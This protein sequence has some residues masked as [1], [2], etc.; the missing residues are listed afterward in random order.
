[1]L[2]NFLKVLLNSIIINWRILQSWTQ[3]A[4]ILQL[5]WARLRLR[6][7]VCSWNLG[8]AFIFSKLHISYLHLLFSLESSIIV[9]TNFVEVGC[10]IFWKLLSTL[11]IFLTLT[12]RWLIFFVNLAHD[13]R[14]VH[15]S[16]IIC[17]WSIGLTQCL[18][19]Q[20]SWL[21]LFH[22]IA[23]VFSPLF[24]NVVHIFLV[25]KFMHFYSTRSLI[26][27]AISRRCLGSAQLTSVIHANVVAL[28]TW[29]FTQFLGLLI[30]LS[31][32][33]SLLVLHL[34]LLVVLLMFPTTSNPIILLSIL[35]IH[36]LFFLMTLLLLLI[37]LLLVLLLFESR[38]SLESKIIVIHRD[39]AKLCS[40]VLLLM[41]VELFWCWEWLLILLLVLL[42]WMTT[43]RH[44]L[45]LHLLLLLLPVLTLISHILWTRLLVS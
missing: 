20:S 39:A 15:S 31:H 17:R 28:V 7:C 10:A 30:F 24:C 22:E 1:M 33:L 45:L 25:I 41:M 4:R 6:N 36:L 40:R 44:L 13:I 43:C 32:D 34:L 5:I 23:E 2:V 9:L 21:G 37:H 3:I 19:S 27:C 42:P 18:T 14:N 16:L 38:R 8:T 35:L 11:Q 26:G 29:I 12:R